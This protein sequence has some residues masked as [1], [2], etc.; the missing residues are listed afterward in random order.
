MRVEQS[1]ALAAP[2]ALQDERQHQR[3]FARPGRSDDVNVPRA[4]LV[5]ERHFGGL[6]GVRVG[7]E[8]V[9]VAGGHVRCSSRLPGLAN[10]LLDAD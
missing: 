6:A 7:P 10:K 5:I 9:V 4:L 8:D 3:G 2:Q 1:Q